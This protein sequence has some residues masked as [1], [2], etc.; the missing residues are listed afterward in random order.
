MFLIDSVY[1][2]FILFLKSRF[3]AINAILVYLYV[4][5]FQ[6]VDEEEYGGLWEI[7]KEGFMTSFSTFLV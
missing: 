5:M 7:I 2:T 4:T 3:A 6:K 1:L